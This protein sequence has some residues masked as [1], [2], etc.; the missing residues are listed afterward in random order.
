MGLR[1]SDCVLCSKA[2]Y[3]WSGGLYLSFG[4]LYEDKI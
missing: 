1:L 4:A 3:I 2:L